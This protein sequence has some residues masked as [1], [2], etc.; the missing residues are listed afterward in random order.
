M[1]AKAV[2][3]LHCHLKRVEPLT[4][5]LQKVV[6]MNDEWFDCKHGFSSKILHPIH[7]LSLI[8]NF[9]KYKVCCK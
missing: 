2:D 9:R 6:D 1:D 7:L 4:E 8:G 3:N 5:L